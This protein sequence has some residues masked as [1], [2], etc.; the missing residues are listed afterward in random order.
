M[1]EKEKTL[2]PADTGESQGTWYVTGDNLSSIKPNVKSKE[3]LD[4]EYLENTYLRFSLLNYSQKL[5]LS[6]GFIKFNSNSFKCHNVAHDSIFSLVRNPDSNRAYYNGLIT[7]HNAKLCPVCSPRIMGF[8]SAE[9]KLAVHNWLAE[10]PENTCYM[11]TLTTSHS[12]RDSYKSLLSRFKKALKIFWENCALRK[13]LNSAF[14]IGRIT[15]NE[16]QY[17][18]INGFHPHQHILLFCKFTDFDIDLLKKYW[19][20][21]LDAVG[22]SGSVDNGLNLIEARS[23]SCYL[24]K[25]SCE[26]TMGNLKQ[27][28]NDG[29]Y[30][31]MQILYEAMNG[32]SWASDVFCEL[33]DGMRGLDS[34][35]W[36]RGLKSRLGVCE[37]SDEAIT[38]GGAQ[39][40]LEKFIDVFSTGLKKL[41]S[42][43]KALLRNYASFDDYER[44][45]ILLKRYNIPFW[46]DFNKEGVEL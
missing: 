7:C 6:R 46:K 41:S 12:I 36:S 38:S 27:G 25:I 43:N 15:S 18:Q 20:T 11:L 30:S 44:A 13:I 5:L 32:Q 23:A 4:K 34:L 31:P 28:R 21:A 8:R 26:M 17:S 2:L 1:S 29:H 45:S 35:R 3:Q 33:F 42:S 9:I 22:L 16:T 39:K 37:V 24:T 40:G 19:L 10:A 14:Y